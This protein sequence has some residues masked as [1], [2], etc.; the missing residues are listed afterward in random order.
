MELVLSSLLP[1]PPVS[2]ST[3]CFLPR[4]PSTDPAS[5]P[6]LMMTQTPPQEREKTKLVP[7]W[8]SSATKLRYHACFETRSTRR[9]LMCNCGVSGQVCDDFFVV[10]QEQSA[11]V[12]NV[13]MCHHDVHTIVMGMD[14]KKDLSFNVCKTIPAPNSESSEKHV[15]KTK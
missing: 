9:P 7:H 2:V 3:R 12:N 4:V 14:R 6:C 15:L 5:L 11:A 1:L 13:S 8:P 10:R